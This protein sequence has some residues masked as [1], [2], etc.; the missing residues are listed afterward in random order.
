M[1]H[2]LSFFDSLLNLPLKSGLLGHL[3][4]IFTCLYVGHR[5]SH[6]CRKHAA[7]PTASCRAPLSSPQLCY[8]FYRLCFCL[9]Y[10]FFF[11]KIWKNVVLITHRHWY[12]CVL[13]EIKEEQTDF[14]QRRNA[15]MVAEA[16]GL[17]GAS[18]G[19]NSLAP[20]LHLNIF[21]RTSDLKPD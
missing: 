16:T 2:F 3:A 11:F 21:K 10:T 8:S 6:P 5:G 7:S 4:A 1:T 14:W 19:P 18:R 17:A 15:Q 13:T 12:S 9:E 20:F